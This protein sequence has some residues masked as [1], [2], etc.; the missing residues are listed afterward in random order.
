M[1]ININILKKDKGYG[2]NFT[3]TS[4]INK[5]YSFT[6]HTKLSSL[7][8]KLVRLIKRYNE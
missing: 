2:L 1:E 4:E 5:V 7:I 6:N 3:K 8:N